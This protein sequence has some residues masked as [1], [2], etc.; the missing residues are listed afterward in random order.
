MG[1]C[2]VAC[3]VSM[4]SSELHIWTRARERNK[5]LPWKNITDFWKI[6]ERVDIFFQ[7]DFHP[8]FHW[9]FKS[10]IFARN[11]ARNPT[12]NPGMEHQC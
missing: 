11:I 10:D 12:E 3:K 1:V 7:A 6:R 2:S 5:Q 4:T 9:Y 8:Y